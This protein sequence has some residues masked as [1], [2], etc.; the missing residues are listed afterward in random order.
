MTLDKKYQHSIGQR[1]KPSFI[2][3]KQ[4]NRLYCHRNALLK[5][6]IYLKLNFK[7]HVLEQQ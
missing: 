4:I 2:D 5:S 3:I 6:L 7:K 1:V